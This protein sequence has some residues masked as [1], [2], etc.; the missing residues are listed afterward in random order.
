MEANFF[1]RPQIFSPVFLDYKPYLL[2][3]VTPSNY[4]LE[5]YKELKKTG[6]WVTVSIRSDIVFR[7]ELT[8]IFS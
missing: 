5:M 6:N 3:E 8:Y 1:Y 4:N 2:K 7:F